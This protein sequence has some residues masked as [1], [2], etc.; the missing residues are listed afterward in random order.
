MRHWSPILALGL[1]AC[2]TPGSQVKVATLSVEDAWNL[3]ATRQYALSA[4]EVKRSEERRVGKE[5]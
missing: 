2:A 5:C 4:R 3:H 1:A